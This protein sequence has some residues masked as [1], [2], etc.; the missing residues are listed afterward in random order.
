VGRPQHRSPFTGRDDDLDELAGWLDGDDQISVRLVHATGGQGKT[1]LAG[2]LA[3]QC[4]A[5][6]WAV[7][8]VLHTPTRTDADARTSC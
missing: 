8:R 1:R 6:G 2:Y 7:W 5:S 3:G 4:A